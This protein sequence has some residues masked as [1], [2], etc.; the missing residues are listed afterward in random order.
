MRF[1]FQD[2]F[3]VCFTCLDRSTILIHFW[4][5]TVLLIC[6]SWMILLHHRCSN[7]SETHS[8][9]KN[10]S[11]Q[12]LSWRSGRCSARMF[13]ITRITHTTTRQ[14]YLV[15]SWIMSSWHTH[16]TT[17][18]LG[19]GRKKKKK[20]GSLKV[21]GRDEMIPMTIWKMRWLNLV[22]CICIW[23]TFCGLLALTDFERKQVT[24]L[25]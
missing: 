18:A 13:I 9:K 10:L 1:F 14:S 25:L 23:C 4:H 5:C 16:I 20:L 2:V 12:G 3:N 15:K 7:S 11:H 19:G 24:Q 17:K 8:Q 22:I 21:N 6:R